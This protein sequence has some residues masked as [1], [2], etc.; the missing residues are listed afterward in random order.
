M[1]IQQG[2]DRS[3]HEMI[4]RL[5]GDESLVD[6]DSQTQPSIELHHPIEEMKDRDKKSALESILHKLD[7]DDFIEKT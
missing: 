3:D 6:H 1:K 7:I 5:E 4:T 2:Y